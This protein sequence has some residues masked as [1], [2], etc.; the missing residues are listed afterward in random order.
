MR[1][2]L[3]FPGLATINL[4]VIVTDVQSTQ[5]IYTCDSCGFRIADSAG[6][7]HIPFEHL[8][9]HHQGDDLAWSFHHDRCLPT[10]ATYG[11]DVEDLRTERGILRWT[12]HLMS[13]NW[14]ADSNWS[15]VIAGALVSDRA[16]A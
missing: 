16:G 5:I 3:F 7:V 2:H 15:R 14:F 11:V 13:K 9:R 8:S 6:C 10:T 1:Q 12:L 4:E